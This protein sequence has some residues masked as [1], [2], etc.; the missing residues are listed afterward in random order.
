MGAGMWDC[1]FMFVGINAD[2]LTSIKVCLQLAQPHPAQQH[3]HVSV[4]RLREDGIEKRVHTRVEWI[5][6]HQQHLWRKNINQLF[7]LK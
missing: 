4:K 1:V 7:F 5:E 3:Q 6:K 2:K